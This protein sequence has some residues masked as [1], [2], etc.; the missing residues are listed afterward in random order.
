M[1]TVGGRLKSDYRYSASVVY[2]TFPFPNP[3]KQ[4]KE[5]ISKLA[6][7]ILLIRE[8]YP[9]LTLAEMY[10]PD[11]MPEDLKMAHHTLDLAV[12]GLYRKKSFENDDERLQLLFSLY[13][14]LTKENPE[15]SKDY[16][17]ESEEE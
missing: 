3:T 15:T 6:E 1:R 13:E 7:E 12:D 16:E 2:N 4:Q 14:K 5:Q 17:E 11:K 8:T 9:E 10:D